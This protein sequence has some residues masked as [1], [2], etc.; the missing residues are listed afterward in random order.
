MAPD[1]IAEHDDH[2]C[3]LWSDQRQN[4]VRH[5]VISN[6]DAHPDDAIIL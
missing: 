1:L 6:M 4:K 2:Y 3:E 5:N